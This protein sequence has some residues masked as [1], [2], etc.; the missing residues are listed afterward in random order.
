MGEDR[1]RTS[2]LC[3]TVPFAKLM[4]DID[5]TRDIHLALPFYEDNRNRWTEWCAGCRVERL[6]FCKQEDRLP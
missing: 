5:D 4:T 2:Q 1:Q 6:L 3:R